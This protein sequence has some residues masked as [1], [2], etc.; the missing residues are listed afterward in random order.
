VAD[1]LRLELDGGGVVE[2]ELASLMRSADAADPGAEPAWALTHEPDWERIQSL[3][4][5]TAAAGETALALAAARPAG[6]TDHSTDGVALVI[7]GA[8]GADTADEALLS[9]EYDAEGRVRR[10]GIEAWLEGGAGKR[11][12]ADRSG[13]AASAQRGGLLREATPLAVRFDGEWGSGLHELLRP[14]DDGEGL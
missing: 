14:A 11:I 12:A 4:L 3:R 5:I 6:A 7:A 2:W 10:L 1:R 9:T 8:E 13:D